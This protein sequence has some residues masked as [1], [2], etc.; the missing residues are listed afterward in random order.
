M[1]VELLRN[2]TWPEPSVGFNAWDPRLRVDL[3]KLCSES[4]L[5]SHL[6]FAL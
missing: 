3:S 1:R 6:R 2:R 4:S 5:N